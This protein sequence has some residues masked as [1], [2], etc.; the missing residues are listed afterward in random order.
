MG[1]PRATAQITTTGDCNFSDGNH[2]QIGF[3]PSRRAIP[4]PRRSGAMTCSS[5]GGD[6]PAERNPP[7][8]GDR[9][10]QH[11]ERVLSRGPIRRDII[12]L[13]MEELVDLLFGETNTSM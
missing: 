4:L 3:A 12:G 6:D 7:H 1:L 8:S 2:S 11:G 10:A 13:E 9:V 5:V